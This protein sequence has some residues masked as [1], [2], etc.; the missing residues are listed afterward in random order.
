MPSHVFSQLGMWRDVVSSNERAYAASV[1]WETSR[2]HTPSAYDW[3]SYSWLVAAHLELGQRV[4]ARKLLDE[5]AALLRAATDDSSGLRDNYLSMVTD[6]ATQTGRWSEVDALI[7]PVF[8]RAYDEDPPGG[9]RIACAMHAPGGKGAA[10]L[11]SVLF[12]RLDG[13]VFRAE[14]AVHLRD[15]DAARKWVAEAKAQESPVTLW[16]KVLAPDW[17][18]GWEARGDTLLVRAHAA[19]TPSP[20]ANKKAADALEAYL[21]DHSDGS[22]SGPA[23]EQPSRE[24]LGQARLAA[25]QPKEALVQFEKVLHARPERA[26]SLLGAARA[27]KACG[28]A[29]TARGRYRELAE[30]WKDADADVPELGEVKAGAGR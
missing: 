8:A 26:L 12:A 19:M 25:D 16:T 14:A 23:M 18:R 22:E 20:A 9:A 21:K 13:D 15:E 1:A 17:A 7:A 5:A 10:R 4:A 2:K 28:E 30:L 29:E 11:P 24:L 3:H 6:Y 27:A